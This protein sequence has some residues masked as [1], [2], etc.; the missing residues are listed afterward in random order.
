MSLV[1]IVSL[2]FACICVC[3]VAHGYTTR[4][5]SDLAGHTLT[6]AGGPVQCENL[7]VIDTSTGTYARWPV[8]GK[9]RLKEKNEKKNPYVLLLVRAFCFKFN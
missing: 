6:R 1:F 8:P 3:I 7:F 9:K 2:C 4:T 5:P